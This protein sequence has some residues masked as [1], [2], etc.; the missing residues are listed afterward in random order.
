[1]NADRALEIDSSITIDEFTIN[2]HAIAIG[3][4][5]QVIAAALAA[6]DAFWIRLNVDGELRSV[7]VHGGTKVSSR[8]AI[9]PDA[10]KHFEDGNL[11]ETNL[12]GLVDRY[13]DR[14]AAIWRV[15]EVL[16][17]DEEIRANHAAAAREVRE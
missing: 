10:A 16:G 1:M 11:P 8:T 4:W 9:T 5:E 17:I 13:I 12:A 14:D 7:L 6:G 2:A 15:V 3:L